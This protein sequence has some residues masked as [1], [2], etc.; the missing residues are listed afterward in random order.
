MYAKYSVY[1]RGETMSNHINKG[2]LIF[3]NPYSKIFPLMNIVSIILGIGGIIGIIWGWLTFGN[4][5]ISTW[6]IL[7]WDL[8]IIVCVVLIP[9]GIIVTL[10]GITTQVLAIYENGFTPMY[11]PLK[12]ALRRQEVFIP[13][14][15]VVYI[16]YEV[17][18]FY[19][20]YYKLNGKIWCQAIGLYPGIGSYLGKKFEKKVKKVC[21]KINEVWLKLQREGKLLHEKPKRV[22]MTL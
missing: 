8:F 6:N 9:A 7:W 5:D 22:E 1:H 3:I 13:W 11:R 10:S 14:D 2:K 19:N 17:G 15:D 18:R 12:Y 16:E 4:T 20:I 21:E